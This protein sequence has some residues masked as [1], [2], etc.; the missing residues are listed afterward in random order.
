[1]TQADTSVREGWSSRVPLVQVII[2]STRPGRFAEKPA[3]WMMDRLAG[4]HELD[5]ELVDLRDYPLPIYEQASSPARTLRD[6]PTEPIARF[7]RVIDRADGYLIITSEYNH[8]NRP[9]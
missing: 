2:G 8:G 3:A 5:A 6:Y 9:R 4:R 7:G 1:V